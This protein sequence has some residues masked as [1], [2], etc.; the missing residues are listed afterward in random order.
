MAE[1]RRSLRPIMYPRRVNVNLREADYRRLCAAASELGVPPSYLGREA[2]LLGFAK[3]TAKLRRE[4]LDDVKD[5]KV[6]GP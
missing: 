4:R 2:L 5:Q 1:G 6:V 3:A